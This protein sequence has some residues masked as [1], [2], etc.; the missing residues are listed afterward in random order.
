MSSPRLT[1]S[2]SP[3]LSTVNVTNLIDLYEYRTST[4]L[5]SYGVTLLAALG[6]NI[7]GLIAFGRNEVVMDKS[8]SSTASATQH[9]HLVDEENYGRRGSIPIPKSVR[10]KKVQFRKLSGG[11]WG[12]YVVPEDESEG[13]SE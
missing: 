11:G 10:E 8:F 12:F 2:S 3:V 9:T 1:L 13:H 5:I 4:L 7:L 6:A